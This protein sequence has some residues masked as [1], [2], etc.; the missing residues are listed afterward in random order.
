MSSQINTS[1]INTNYPVP[2]QNNSSQGFRDNFAQIR[3]NLNTAGN[4]IT[5]L[6]NKVVLKQAL[7]DSVL[8]N[9]MANALISN[10][11]VRSFRHTT[12]NL[13]NALSGTIF[14]DASRADVQY[15]AIAGNTTLQFG[16]WAPTNTEQTITLRLTIPNASV[17]TS[18]IQLPNACISSNNNYGTTILENYTQ[19][20]N[21]ATITAPANVG[22]IELDLT[23]T[24]CGNSISVTPTNRPFQSTQIVT[25]DVA[26]TGLQ[27][28]TPGAVAVGPSVN[29]L[30]ITGVNTDPYLTTTG[31]T[32]QLYPDMPI[33]F[34]GTSLAGNIVVG[35]T[36]YVRNIV[37]NTTFTVSS[38]IGGANVAIGA[39]AIGNA[40]FANP[41][42]YMYVCV[43][44]YNSTTY[45]REMS[46]TNVSGN[47]TL[48]ST[49]DLVVN[50][51][52]IFVGNVDGANTN[53]VANTVYYVKTTDGTTPGNI[54]ISRS[55]VNGVA[56][57]A[58]T[59]GNGTPTA[60]AICYVGNDIWRRINLNSW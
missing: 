3:N 15:G 58:T 57:T 55:R 28:D 43:D 39:N 32:S 34:T 30:N 23:T 22:I 51:P 17:A 49:A 47:I 2:G 24:D 33:V 19:V 16:G 52:I 59:L 27:G 29:Q 20:G 37:S 18:L 9:D 31:S 41:A 14:V 26:P 46:A 21:V 4:E 10:A 6:Q 1:G 53:L 13:G 12:Y 38:T 7:T 11:S 45:T 40:M 50:A 36:Y 5:D 54:T 44:T 56:G 60:N 35:N 25:R 42:S 48:N 8:N